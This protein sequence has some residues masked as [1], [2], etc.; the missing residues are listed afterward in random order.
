MGADCRPCSPRQ[1]EWLQ[2]SFGMYMYMRDAYA[3]SH[4]LGER[5]RERGYNIRTSDGAG[6]F[7]S[8]VWGR[9]RRWHCTH[10]ANA[11]DY[12]HYEKY[13]KAYA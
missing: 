11:R 4:I 2:E 9:R 5:E 7:T 10:S 6:D 8:G 1:V 3:V 13:C 12:E